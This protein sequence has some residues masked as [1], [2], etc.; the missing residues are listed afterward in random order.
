[1]TVSNKQLVKAFK[2][3]KKYLWDGKGMYRPN[4]SEIWICFALSKAREKGM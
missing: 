2:A 3:A 1:M 4:L